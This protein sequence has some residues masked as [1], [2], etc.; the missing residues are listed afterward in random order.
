MNELAKKGMDIHGVVVMKGKEMIPEIYSFGDKVLP[1]KPLLSQDGSMLIFEKAV[2]AG[3]F[4]LYS[5]DGNHRLVCQAGSVNSAAISPDGKFIGICNGEVITVLSVS[6]G[7]TYRAII[8]MHSSYVRRSEK[9]DEQVR[10]MPQLRL[11]QE[12]P[13]RIVK[14]ENQY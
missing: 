6:D 14:I 9:W 12:V 8:S 3:K 4:Y 5:P 7:T 13:S 10:K 1:E 2:S 11:L